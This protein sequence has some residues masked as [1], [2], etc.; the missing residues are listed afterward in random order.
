MEIIDIG[1][2]HVRRPE[3]LVT[4]GRGLVGSQISADIKTDS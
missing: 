4:G 1:E 2:S 3:L